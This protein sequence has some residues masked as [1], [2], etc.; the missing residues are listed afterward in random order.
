MPRASVGIPVYNTA[1]YLR[2][3]IDSALAQTFAAFEVIVVNDGST[4]A[5]GRT[6]RA[7]AAA[8]ARIRAHELALGDK[9]NAWN[10]YVHRLAPEDAQMHVFIDADVR[11]APGAFPSLAHALEGGE[12]PELEPV[13]VGGRAHLQRLGRPRVEQLVRRDIAAMAWIAPYL[14]GRLPVAAVVARTPDTPKPPL[15]KQPWF[16]GVIAGVMLRPCAFGPAVCESSAESH[17]ALRQYR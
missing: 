6:A 10:D 12:V 3:A 13:Q 11:A 15:V 14:V 17:C 7:L 1:R 16:W 2:A 8:D 5:T 9:A 4:D